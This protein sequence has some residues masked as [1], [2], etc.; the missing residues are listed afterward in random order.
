MQYVLI[1]P[2]A[3]ISTVLFA[4]PCPNGN[5]FLYKGDSLEDVLKQC[6][7]PV[8]K[9]TDVL[10]LSTFQQWIYYRGHAYD[11]GFSQLIISFKNDRV[12]SIRI[13][14]HYNT[15]YPVCRQF[16][17]Q[18]GL[19]TTVETTCGDSSYLTLFTN[20]C[21]RGFGIGETNEIVKS[22]CG[23]PASQTKLQ[24]DTIETTEL[25]YDGTEPQTI[26]F[27]NGKLVDWK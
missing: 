25:K 22:I 12:S 15:W 2:L 8:T 18:L 1:L 21:S 23:Q 5:G 24:S 20:L 10:V 4:L 17:V 9:K 16:A 11:N 13:N 6:G 26:V 19:V 14:D 7:A 27:T 3:L